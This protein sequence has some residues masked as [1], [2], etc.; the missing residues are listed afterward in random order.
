[1]I[2]AGF[3]EYRYCFFSSIETFPFNLFVDGFSPKHSSYSNSQ[4][5]NAL[6]GE[7]IRSRSTYFLSSWGRFERKANAPYTTLVLPAPG[8]EKLHAFCE[9]ARWYADNNCNSY[10]L[11]LDRFILTEST[12]RSKSSL[13]H[14]LFLIR[15]AFSA[16][17]PNFS[18]SSA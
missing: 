12:N 1:M 11:L 9:K 14:S 18:S 16:N 2:L 17:S 13:S 10:R 5:P 6:S 4:G 7:M 15:R 8:T 3:S